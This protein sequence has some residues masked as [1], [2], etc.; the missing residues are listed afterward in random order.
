MATSRANCARRDAALTQRELAAPGRRENGIVDSR[1][2]DHCSGGTVE[3]RVRA[4]LLYFRQ[5]R[6]LWN[7]DVLQARLVFG[8]FTILGKLVIPGTIH[9]K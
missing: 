6:C 3:R 5:S 4:S 8:L 9:S 2:V 1:G 7:F